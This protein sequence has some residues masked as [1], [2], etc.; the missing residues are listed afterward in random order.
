MDSARLPPSFLPPD[1]P[2]PSPSFR[3][4]DRLRFGNTPV[5]SPVASPFRIVPAKLVDALIEDERLYLKELNVL[6]LIIEEHLFGHELDPLEKPVEDIIDLASELSR[7]LAKTSSYFSD[8]QKECLLQF[9]NSATAAYQRYFGAFRLGLSCSLSQSPERIRLLELL[10]GLDRVGE[11]DRDLDWLLRRPLSRVRAYST[12]Y[13]KLL[14]SSDDATDMFLAYETFHSL[15]IEARETLETAREQLTQTDE[16]AMSLRS[17]QRSV[18]G[19]STSTQSSSNSKISG[20]D[21]LAG[22]QASIDTSHCRDIFSLAPTQC[23]IDLISKANETTK[24]ILVNRENFQMQTQTGPAEHRLDCLVE[25]VLLTDQILLV[26]PTFE[27]PRL[28]FPPLLRGVYH[29]SC[30]TSDPAKLEMDIVG[31]QTLHLTAPSPAARSHWYELL[32]ACEDFRLDAMPS[33]PRT[34]IEHVG[35]KDHPQWMPLAPARLPPTPPHSSNTPIFGIT[36]P[37]RVIRENSQLSIGGYTDASGR[38]P[39]AK[40]HPPFQFDQEDEQTPRAVLVSDPMDKRVASP[41]RENTTISNQLPPAASGGQQRKP[42][43]ITTSTSGES[44]VFPDPPVRASTVPASTE[45]VKSRTLDLFSP[46]SYTEQFLSATPLTTRSKTLQPSSTMKDMPPT[47]TFDATDF[48]FTKDETFDETILDLPTLP[49]FDFGDG[50]RRPSSMA[51]NFSPQTM[52]NFGI[53]MRKV[54][55]PAPLVLPDVAPLKISPQKQRSPDTL[56]HRRLGNELSLNTPSLKTAPVVPPKRD[57]LFSTMAECYS[58]VHGTWTPILMDDVDSNGS[59]KT[60]RS[61]LVTIFFSQPQNGSLEIF[62]KKDEKVLHLFGVYAGSSIIRDDSCD[63]SVGFDVGFDKV[64]YM[65]RAENPDKANAMQHAL[66]QAKF[67]APQKGFVTPCLPVTPL[68]PEIDSAAAMIESLKLKLYIFDNGK[69]VNKGSARLT[70]RMISQSR[71]RRITLTGKTR[72]NERIMLVDYIAGSGD[73]DAI[74][75][76]SIALRT[77]HETYMMQ[78][79]GGEKERSKV[80]GYLVD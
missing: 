77:T 58:W 5:Q 26:R 23:K 7:Q 57:E 64:Y 19:G 63:I 35:R 22:L 47:P 65:F 60:V 52:S 21:E 34:L 3:H 68:W 53:P 27:G 29:I 50:V 80:L 12:I 55:A 48:D 42:D 24:R 10:Q 38:T 49:A 36:A 14:H 61:S 71:N 72:K 44:L 18:S 13:K 32:L 56:A 73:C 62:D 28:V 78:F 75:K 6:R 59:M 1:L 67:A 20:A 46:Q 2:L 41:L 15:L 4:A 17:A 11:A 31:R 54:P 16:S 39:E 69:W 40:D 9:S 45:M 30:I 51:L 66:N 25:L 74:S 70:I 37:L 8:T 76:T 79:K 33:V 43:Q